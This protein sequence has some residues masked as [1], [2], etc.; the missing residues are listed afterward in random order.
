MVQRNQSTSSPEEDQ[1]SSWNVAIYISGDY[2]VRQ[3]ITHFVIISTTI[4]NNLFLEKLFYIV[5]HHKPQGHC[6]ADDTQPYVSFSPNRSA[7]ADTAIK[8][9]WLHQ[10][11][12]ELDAEFLILDRKQQLA[13]V[14][15][16]YIKVGS[17]N[18]RPISV[19]SVL[20]NLIF[21][22]ARILLFFS[23]GIYH[24]T[25]KSTVWKAGCG[26]D[27]LKG[28]AGLMNS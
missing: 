13:K 20:R 17:A 21:T 5:E 22:S 7:E 9:I 23:G 3:T 28:R 12:E 8:S 4:N 10:W 11:F 19:V 15:I 6:Y 1:Q 25:P 16:D 27:C 14:N 2:I 24:I 18:V 26:F